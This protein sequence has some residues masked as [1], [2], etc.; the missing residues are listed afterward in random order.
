MD[1]QNLRS[2]IAS[3]DGE[4]MDRQ[5]LKQCWWNEKLGTITLEDDLA[6][7][8]SYTSSQ[9]LHSWEWARWKLSLGVNRETW[10]GIFTATSC[11][12]TK[13]SGKSQISTIQKDRSINKLQSSNTPIN[14]LCLYNWIRCSNTYYG[15][16]LARQDWVRRA[17]LENQVRRPVRSKAKQ[18]TA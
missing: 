11:A 7:L 6:I 3:R 16:L 15:W 14:S 9:Q 13:K 5:E 8:W 12:I 18:K 1:L 10:K 2:L 4:P 17:S